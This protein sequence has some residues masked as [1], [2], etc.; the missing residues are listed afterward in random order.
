MAK[1]GTFRPILALNV[2]KQHKI[3]KKCTKNAYKYQNNGE[4]WLWNGPK[5]LLFSLLIDC[6]LAP[7]SVQCFKATGQKF[8]KYCHYMQMTQPG[9]HSWLQEKHAGK[10]LHPLPS[11][12]IRSCSNSEQ[13]TR[14]RNISQP[15][16][17]ILQIT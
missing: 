17:H 10:V 1:N 3:G 6:L 4:I 16:P 14:R 8:K 9:P 7:F 15:P 5:K 2:F 13:D 12:H 11:A